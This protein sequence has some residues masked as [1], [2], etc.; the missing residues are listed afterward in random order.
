MSAWDMYFRPA[1][2]SAFQRAAAPRVVEPVSRERPL[3]ARWSLMRWMTS[4]ASA[5]SSVPQPAAGVQVP[6]IA[7]RPGP[8]ECRTA[9][10]AT[11]RTTSANARKRGVRGVTRVG[12]LAGL[13]AGRKGAEIRRGPAVWRAL[14]VHSVGVWP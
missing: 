10:T 12:I 3:L 7:A 11:V 14:D 8:E 4:P 5:E 2:C 9:P 6:T 13:D 1:M